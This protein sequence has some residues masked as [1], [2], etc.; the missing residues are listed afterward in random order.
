M[1]GV[2]HPAPRGPTVHPCRDNPYAA[3]L[4]THRS[5]HGMREDKLRSLRPTEGEP[6]PAAA[7]V[8]SSFRALALGDGYT[9]TAARS[10]V[11]R[12]DYRFGCYPPLGGAAA[13]GAL[14]AD[15]WD[16]VEEFPVSDRFASFVA[17]FDGPVPATETDFEELL[18]GQLQRLH[19]LDARHSAWDGAVSDDPTERG[20]SFSFAGRAFFIV[21]M[22]AAA[23]RWAR[24]TAWPTLV[25]NAHAQFEILRDTGRIDRMKSV[26]RTRDHRLQGSEN[27]SLA[28]FD[29]DSETVMY[30]GR[31]VEP[32]W[33][34]P[35][36]VR[37]S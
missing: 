28:R 30:S 10:A 3:A 27:P 4:G 13:T 12:G 32:E 5:Y 25:F 37:P 14:A 29:W 24:R 33:S 21:G 31:L 1:T 11:R 34:C 6:E 23:S 8:H 18:W 7:L 17:S 20:F 16:F 35:L 2:A 19:D 26:V 22:H 9:C 36:Q 15:L